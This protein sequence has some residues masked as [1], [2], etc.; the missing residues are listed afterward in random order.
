M[1]IEGEAAIGPEKL[2]EIERLLFR[3]AE[4]LDT[5]Q[6]QAFIALFT[7]EGL[8][9]MPAS[10]E[11]TTGEGVPSIFYEDR[12]LMTVRM[13]RL[14]HPHAWSQKTEW[15]TSHVIGNI[16]VEAHDRA[17]GAVTVRSRFHMMEFRNDTSRHF[18]GRYTHHLKATPEGYRI[19]LQRVDMVNAQG[20]YDY[21]L[22][23]W[24]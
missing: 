17:A 14:D 8:Y 20:P 19:T 13:K 21:V 18:A 24:V 10:P 5:R 1:M 23:A 4:C 2:R 12:D 6:W 3:Q 15:G 7:P 22:Q 16:I 9:W 11:Q